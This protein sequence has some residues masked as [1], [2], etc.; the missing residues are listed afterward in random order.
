VSDVFVSPAP[1]RTRS[2]IASALRSVSLTD[3]VR[4]LVLAAAYYGAAKLG[5]TLR[6]TASV[7]AIWPPVGLGIAVLYLG[8]LR[9]WPGIF[10]GEL[11]VNGELLLSSVPLPV[12]SLV[13]QQLGN[14]AE[15]LLG[16]WLLRRLIGP[17]AKL[18]RASQVSGMVLA[19]GVATA[20]SATAGT[21]S[22]LAGDVITLASAP[23]FW[24][25]WWLGDTSGVLV[26]VPLVL[27]WVGHFRTA[28]RRMWT[29]EGGF[30]LAAVAALT[31]VA[32]TS[33]PLLY[34]SF[35]ALIWAA[36]RFGPAG[37]TLAVLVNAGLTIGITAHQHGAFFRQPIDDRTL[38]TQL[39][40]LIGTL[41]ALYLSAAVSERQ[42]SAAE[43]VA[44]RRRE[45][46]HAL[47][48]RRR[49]ARDLHDSVSQ[50]LFSSMLHTRT[51]ERALD[52]DPRR[53]LPKLRESLRAIKDL[54][55]GAQDEMRRFIFEWGPHGVGEGLR[56]AFVR[57][58]PVI[59]AGSSVVVEIDCPAGKLPLATDAQAQLLGI[60]REAIANVVK[61]SGAGIAHVR[62]D[63]RPDAVV[64]EVTDDGCG[65]DPSDHH[66]G[67]IG[68]D[69][70][71]S[72]A[73]ELGAELT[74]RSAPNAGTA[75]RVEVPRRAEERPSG[76]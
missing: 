60:G 43:L 67:G 68:L 25:T 7:A 65:F 69:S 9:L 32:V 16:A 51:A 62:L 6:Y 24:R 55:R 22:M 53:A 73:A 74:I 52:G 76:G 29:V 33:S 17:R 36:F 28:I 26:V 2:A 72:R 19:A 3:V 12:G 58:A 59:T 45:S 47:E 31:T 23:T 57:V 10:L 34:L 4:M 38:S 46:E 48:D 63:V 14:M 66:A 15:I 40:V 5:H 44:S 18:D 71:S 39:Y 50:T 56:S 35:P 41:T 49:I 20:V 61:H 21:L 11:V 1:P 54:T 37:V 75:I 64:L 42:R 30:L 70:M 8:G 27:T 13:G